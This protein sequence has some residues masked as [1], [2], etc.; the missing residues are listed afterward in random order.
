MTEDRAPLISIRTLENRQP[1]LKYEKSFKYIDPPLN[2]CSLESKQPTMS[3]FERTKRPQNKD[4]TDN[5]YDPLQE[6]PREALK[7][8]DNITR[9][10][11]DSCSNRPLQKAST[12][13]NTIM[14]HDI[15]PRF[16]NCVRKAF[17]SNNMGIIKNG[18]LQQRGEEPRSVLRQHEPLL[19]AETNNFVS[20]TGYQSSA[21]QLHAPSQDIFPQH[22]PLLLAETNNFGYN[23]SHQSSASQLPN[24]DT[25]PQHIHHPSPFRP[26]NSYRILSLEDQVMRNQSNH[27][28][29]MHSESAYANEQPR[30]SSNYNPGIHSDTV[31][32]F[33]HQSDIVPNTYSHIQTGTVDIINLD[34][35]TSYIGRSSRFQQLGPDL[36]SSSRSEQHLKDPYSHK[37]L[38][39]RP[40]LGSSSRSEQHLMSPYFHERLFENPVQWNPD[41]SSN[42]MQLPQHPPVP[43]TSTH[44]QQHD[45]S[46]QPLEASA[47]WAQE[48]TDWPSYLGLDVA[49]NPYMMSES[50][51][52][53]SRKT[54]RSISPMGSE[55][56]YDSSKIFSPSR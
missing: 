56:G 23:T 41:E 11:H 44:N 14:A 34:S 24:Q 42:L 4:M 28:A 47:S 49:S 33:Y 10:T 38:F 12:W 2:Y 21:S 36:G 52:S 22:E 16:K 19:Q 37:R 7:K 30:T 25:F 48:N 9:M 15:F 35:S 18:P 50:P 6:R 29:G 5:M 13:S 54:T 32:A 55:A 40:D 26:D 39:E 43:S 27:A 51:Q 45:D 20:N 17:T 31:A 3:R 1:P 8:W 46:P 53:Y